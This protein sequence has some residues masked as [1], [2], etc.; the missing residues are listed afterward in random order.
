MNKE[1]MALEMLY[2]LPL[3]QKDAKKTLCGRPSDKDT[4]C[5]MPVL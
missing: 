3:I 1:R 4:S 5:E 2:V